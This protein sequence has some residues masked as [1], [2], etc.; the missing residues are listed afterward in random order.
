MRWKWKVSPRSIKRF[1]RRGCKWIGEKVR[2][3]LSVRERERWPFSGS[4]SRK[5]SGRLPGSSGNSTI[6]PVT[7]TFLQGPDLYYRT[8]WN[9]FLIHD[10]LH[11]HNSSAKRSRDVLIP[12]GSWNTSTEG[13]CPWWGRPGAPPWGAFSNWCPSHRELYFRLLPSNPTS[14]PFKIPVIVTC[15]KV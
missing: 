15:W 11:L 1:Y 6:H 5:T 3:R 4:L 8:E 9:K 7:H 14:H 13:P 12:V 10:R 2:E